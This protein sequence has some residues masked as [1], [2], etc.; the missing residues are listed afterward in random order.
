M[1]Q[2]L[3]HAGGASGSAQQHPQACTS[4]SSLACT[5]MN[6]TATMDDLSVHK[7]NSADHW[8]KAVVMYMGFKA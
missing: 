5:C 2:Y 6:V 4:H 7:Q 8:S 1:E 3:E